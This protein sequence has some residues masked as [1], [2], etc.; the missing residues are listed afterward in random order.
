MENNKAFTL[1]NGGKM[2]F[3]IAI[4]GSFQLIK[5]IKDFF[6][7]IVEKDVALPVPSGEEL[8]DMVSQYKGIVFSF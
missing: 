3:F 4:R 1:I 2:F 6:V 7:G 8:Y 5:N